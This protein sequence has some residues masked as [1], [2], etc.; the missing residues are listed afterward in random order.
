VRNA[1][2]I[3]VPVHREAGDILLQ[4]DRNLRV[5]YVLRVGTVIVSVCNVL[6]MERW[7]DCE[8]VGVGFVAVGLVE[9]EGV[10]GEDTGRC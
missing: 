8:K 5:L 4:R 10:A 7:R 6:P 1:G 2:L 3:G 9:V